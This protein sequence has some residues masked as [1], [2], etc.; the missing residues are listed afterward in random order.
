MGNEGITKNDGAHH[1]SSVLDRE[2]TEKI[3]FPVCISDGLPTTGCGIASPSSNSDPQ[4][5]GKPNMMFTVSAT[6][7]VTVL[8]E[9]DNKPQFIAKG[10]FSVAENQPRFTQVNGRLSAVDPDEGENG[11]VS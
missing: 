3:T 4:L 10:P 6:V 9:N 1:I 5:S 7:F 2:K 8:D 11:L